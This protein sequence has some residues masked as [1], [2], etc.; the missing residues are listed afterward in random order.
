M[1]ILHWFEKFDFIL[2]L[3]LQL[4]NFEILYIYTFFLCSKFRDMYALY[5]NLI[6][7][8]ILIHLIIHDDLTSNAIDQLNSLTCII[9]SI[10]L[11][12]TQH[13]IPFWPLTF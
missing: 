10:L 12:P 4:W 2:A 3:Q 8:S 11:N 7:N 9:S 1:Y 13:D 6:S 5:T